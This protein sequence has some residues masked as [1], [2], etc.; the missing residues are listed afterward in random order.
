MDSEE[1]MKLTFRSR[2]S[3]TVTL[4]IPADTLK[5]LQK[6][7]ATHDMSVEALIKLYVGQGLR[8]DLARNFS[9]RIL[10]RT[11]EV[12]SRHIK[13]EQELSNILNEIRVETTS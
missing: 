12:L 11:A 5:S 7:A 4:V 8:Q 6:I 2:P 10:E 13:S 1:T 9:E 3:E